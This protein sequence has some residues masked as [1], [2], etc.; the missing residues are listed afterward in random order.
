L[1]YAIEW[2]RMADTRKEVQRLKQRLEQLEK[3]AGVTGS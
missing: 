2:A 1:R 3:G